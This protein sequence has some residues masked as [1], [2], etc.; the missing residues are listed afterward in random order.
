[1]KL[2][3]LVAMKV[4]KPVLQYVAQEHKIK[5]YGATVEDYAQAIVKSPLT[6]ETAELLALEYRFAGR[7]AVNIFNPISGIMVV[8][9][10]IDYFV[11]QL[12]NKYGQD[13]LGKGLRPKLSE[14]PRIYNVYKRENALILSFTYLGKPQ[15]QYL[16]YEIVKHS[17]QLMDFVVIHFNPFCVEIRAALI[18]EKLLKNAILEVMGID[19]DKVEW[20][21]MTRLSENK[22][23][24]LALALNAGLTGAK[25]KMEEGIYDFKEVKANSQVKN[26]YDQKEY[27]E[28]F[29]GLPCKKQ[30]FCFQYT[31]SFGYSTKV[32]LKI[33]KN[34]LNFLSDVPEEVITYVVEKLIDI[35]K[36]DIQKTI[37]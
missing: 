5:P 31:Y 32:V 16:N 30:T 27:Q 7:T 17:P 11:K 12:V 36:Q 1:M 19:E 9:D 15:K 24:Q 37:A 8:W 21:I 26:L 35:R 33:T 18:K 4:P 14:K 25:H 28:E 13:I 20:D 29:Q 23:Y 34:G 22:A 10:N 2:E 6:K 3:D